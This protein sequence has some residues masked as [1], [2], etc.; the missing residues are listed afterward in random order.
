MSTKDRPLTGLKIG[1]SISESEDLNDRGFTNRDVTLI[2]V[3]LCR[4]IV[5]LGG[6]VVLGHQWRPQGL[7]DSVARFAQI[8]RGESSTPDEP[9]IYNFLASPHKAA[10]SDSDRRELEGFIRIKEDIRGA[11]ANPPSETGQFSDDTNAAQK[12]MAANLTEMRRQMSSVVNA[13]ICLGGKTKQSAGLVHGVLEEAALDLG[14]R[15][16]VYLSGLMGGTSAVLVSI[17]RQ[18]IQESSAKSRLENKHN[19]RNALFQ[20]YLGI[21]ETLKLPQLAQRCGFEDTTANDASISKLN[22]L[23]DAQNLET[24]VELVAH[25][26]L[27][28]KQ[29]LLAQSS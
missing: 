19:K 2:T 5:S 18:G 9:I 4:R 8:Y 23:F 21:F 16:P 13:R 17:L 6:A 25:G 29:Q 22:Q 20:G 3:E 7:M 28:R 1:I 24:I 10:L 27:V 15:H 12:V 14:N 26:I 11:P